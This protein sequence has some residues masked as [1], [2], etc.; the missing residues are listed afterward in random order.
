MGRALARLVDLVL[1]RQILE[2][3]EGVLCGR[4]FKYPAEVASSII[5]EI[6]SISEIVAPS[7]RIDIVQADPYDNMILECAAAGRVDYIVSGDFHLLDLGEFEGIKI[8]SVVQLLEIM[9]RR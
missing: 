2:E 3:L 6:E 1:S 8:V 5:Q 4:K 9:E 7:R